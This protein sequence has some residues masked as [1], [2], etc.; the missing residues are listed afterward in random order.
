[1]ARL[2]FVVFLAILLLPAAQAANS[3]QSGDTSDC[4][5]A[6]LESAVGSLLAR[7]HPTPLTATVDVSGGSRFRVE[8]D[9]DRVI[10]LFLDG[11]G[12]FV[13]RIVGAEEGVV[14]EAA[15]RAQVC[16]QRAIG[17]AYVPALV[18]GW[19]YQDGL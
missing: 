3:P 6:V 5:D 4:H 8:S 17:P 14:P 10:L 2:R 16:V 9:G 15:A 18:A 1:M 7:E 13:S 19:T 12:A 11:R